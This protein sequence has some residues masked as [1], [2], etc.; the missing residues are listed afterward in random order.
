MNRKDLL[1]LKPVLDAVEKNELFQFKS[2]DGLYA[3]SFEGDISMKTLESFLNGEC[4]LSLIG[5]TP[6]ST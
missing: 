3:T 2:Q 5:K 4:Y 6:Y 1:K